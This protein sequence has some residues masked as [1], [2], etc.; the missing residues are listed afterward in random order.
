MQAVRR[1]LSSSSKMAAMLLLG[2]LVA[3]ALMPDEAAAQPVD[4]ARYGR[5]LDQLSSGQSV[6]DEDIGWALDVER[7][8][9]CP[10]AKQQTPEEST[11]SP[12]AASSAAKP[13]VLREVPGPPKCPAAMPL[14]TSSTD[15]CVLYAVANAYHTG[16]G[17]PLDPAKG[18]DFMLKAAGAGSPQAQYRM[19]LQH[20]PQGSGPPKNPA[21]YLRWMRLAADQG[22]VAAQ[23]NVASIYLYGWG[24]PINYAESARW[25]TRAMEGG[26]VLAATSLAVQ[27]AVGEGFP[28]DPAKAAQYYA[29]AAERGEPMAQYMLGVAYGAGEGVPFDIYQARYWLQ[30]SAAQNYDGAADRLAEAEAIIAQQSSRRNGRAT[31]RPVPQT[32]P[33]LADQALETLKRQRKENCAAAAVG[34][35]RVCIRD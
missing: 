5:V 18:A 7:F 22:H 4:C 32:G 11:P 30:K 29:Y 35:D 9:R 8:N 27:Y 19:G 31:T 20:G 34:R 23:E 17:L 2:G 12:P 1:M 15:P 21:Q 16:K 10:A 26:S 13:F 25:Y 28:V 14:D 24:V 6:A 3:F 33:S